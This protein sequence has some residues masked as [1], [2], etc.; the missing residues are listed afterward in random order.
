MT[1]QHEERRVT[2]GIDVPDDY[3]NP[4]IPPEALNILRQET[5]TIL[6]VGGSAPYAGATHI[7]DILGY[8]PEFLLH[9]AWGGR[10]K[11]EEVWTARQHTQFD[12]LSGKAWPFGNQQFDLGL[13]SHT[14][15]DLT[16]PFPAMREMSRV[17]RRV[18]IICPSR[19]LEQTKGVVHPRTVGFPHHHWMVFATGDSLIFRPKTASVTRRGAYLRCPLGKTVSLDAGAMYYLTDR[20]RPETQTFASEKEDYAECRSFRRLCAAR[21]DIFVHDG[22]AHDVRYWLWKLRQLCLGHS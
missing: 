6:D 18:L 16:D 2:K 12:L 7:L 19:L 13:C 10:R 5:G 21:K 9:K 11:R 4:W 8:N 17:C 22:Y 14:L 3:H 20:L 1:P 15:E